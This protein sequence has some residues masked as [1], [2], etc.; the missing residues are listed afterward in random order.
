MSPSSAVLAAFPPIIRDCSWTLLPPGG[1][2]N[3]AQVWRGDL[4][5]ESLFALKRWPASF[6]P[7]RMRHV[8]ERLQAV[9]NLDFTPRLIPSPIGQTLISHSGHCWEVITWKPGTPDLLTHPSLPQLRAAGVALAQLHRAWLLPNADTA[10]CSAVTRQLNLLTKWEQTRFQFNGR[11][12]ELAELNDSL[13]LV[14]SRVRTVRT[15][16]LTVVSIRGQ[17]FPVHG[18]F[19]PEN[20]LFQNEHLTAVLDFGNVG[21]DH[22]EVD[23]GRLLAD[24][25]GANRT[26]T[27]VAIAGYRSIVPS[28]LSIR[29]VELLAKSGRLGSLANWHLRLNAGSPDVWLL[30]TALPRIRWLV[31]AIRAEV[32]N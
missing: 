25:P 8:H 2:L 18:D 23:L 1:G 32:G 21:F 19:W 4:N 7:E 20:V 27:D 15:E 10:P 31:S 17:V 3:G 29:L 13:D 26:L 12:D 28:E 5:G 11:P 9:A 6:T 24:V 22:P 16:L 30:P 14:R